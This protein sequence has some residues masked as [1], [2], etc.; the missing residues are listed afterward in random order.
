MYIEQLYTG[1]LSAAAYYIE[2]NGEAAVIDPMREPQPYMALAAARGAVIRYVF[3]THFHADYVSGHLDL[4][5]RTGAKIIF[6]PQAS[7]EYE[8]KTAEDGEEFRLGFITLKVLHTPGHTPESSCFLLLDERHIPHSIFTGDTLFVDDVGRPDQMGDSQLTPQQGAGILYDSIENKLLPLP[9]YVVVYPGHGAGSVCGKS[10]GIERHSTIG[11]QKHSNYALKAKSKAEFIKLVTE[12]LNKPPDYFTYV[13]QMNRRKYD[14]L[15]EILQKNLNPLSL[16]QFK[17][18]LNN[19]DAVVIDT[20][21]SEDFERGFIPRSVFV[22]LEGHFAVIAGSVL[23]N[24]KKII[25]VADPGKEQEVISNLARIGIENVTG[26]L[27]GGFKTW[28]EAGESI[29]T[30]AG[31]SAMEFESRFNYNTAIALDVRNPDEWVPGFVAGAKLIS[32]PELNK[33]LV[34]LDKNKMCYVYCMSGFRSMV[35]VS[36]LKRNGFDK[37]YHVQG[38]MV[39]IRKTKVPIKQLI[40]SVS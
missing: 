17:F 36:L 9:N 23:D 28:E 24:R 6:G 25:V 39:K 22:G 2:S 32:L 29:D 19:E 21:N 7:A 12:G 33:G 14:A 40:S 26:Y 30:I 34:A 18:I 27:K 38:G 31:I 16:Q 4:A 35:A 11:N 3:E 8:I 15:E 10:I 1:A 13:A 37:V 5:R 20:R